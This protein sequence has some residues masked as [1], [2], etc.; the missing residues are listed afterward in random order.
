MSGVSQKINIAGIDLRTGDL[1]EVCSGQ[2][3]L[4]SRKRGHSQGPGNG[5]LKAALFRY[6]S[7]A[8][9]NSA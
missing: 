4:S 8:G 2:V 3:P 5:N 7:V 6:R 9:S 1:T